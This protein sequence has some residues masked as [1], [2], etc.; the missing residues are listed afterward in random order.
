MK[1]VRTARVVPNCLHFRCMIPSLVRHKV[2]GRLIKR[3]HYELTKAVRAATTVTFDSTRNELESGV[4]QV[5]CF[6]PADRPPTVILWTANKSVEFQHGGRRARLNGARVSA[7]RAGCSSARVI[8]RAKI[9]LY[10]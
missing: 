2:E 10:L 6:G 7:N 3:A 4:E 9:R 5:S 8:R 1:T